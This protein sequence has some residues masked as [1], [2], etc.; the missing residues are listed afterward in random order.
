MDT[1]QIKKINPIE[2]TALSRDLRDICYDLYFSQGVEA[3][4]QRIDL[5]LQLVIKE[6]LDST[7]N[8]K[9]FKDG[10]HAVISALT[11]GLH[12]LYADKIKR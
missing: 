12:E 4:K 1:I 2:G 11:I 7:S 9:D 10:V 6:K 3:A 5:V 8:T